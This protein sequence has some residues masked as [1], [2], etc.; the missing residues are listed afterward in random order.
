MK[1]E[2]KPN[3]LKFSYHICTFDNIQICPSSMCLTVPH[4][5]PFSAW[6]TVSSNISSQH[7]WQYLQ[8]SLLSSI[9][10]KLCS[11]SAYLTVFPQYGIDQWPPSVELTRKPP[12]ARLLCSSGW[13]TAGSAWLRCCWGVAKCG[14]AVV[15]SDVLCL[16]LLRWFLVSNL[17]TGYR[18]SIGRLL[19]VMVKPSNTAP[20]SKLLAGKPLL[21][22]A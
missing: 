1:L 8:I 15:R 20:P 17:T 11:S 12:L 4:R 3:A 19:V 18:C 21:L 14:P 7:L 10:S 22:L 9:T 6:L 5:C 2:Q 16:Q 13:C